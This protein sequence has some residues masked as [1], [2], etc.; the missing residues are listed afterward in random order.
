MHKSASESFYAGLSPIITFGD[1]LDDAA[2]AQ[3]PDDW[4]VMMSDVRDSTNAIA[5]GRY[6]AVNMVGVAT[7]T[8]VKNCARGEA[9]PFVFGG[10]G[11]T[12]LVPPSLR[13]PATEALARLR[14]NCRQMFDLDL[15][16][17]AIPVADI[18]AAGHRLAVC[19]YQ[20]SPGNYL[21]FLAGTGHAYATDR[22]KDRSAD[23]PYLLPEPDEAARHKTPPELTGL[24]CRWE[25]LQSRRG[26][27]L[28]LII[29][30]L[31]D[32]TEKSE[33]IGRPEINVAIDDILD[34]DMRRF[35]PASLTNLR[36]R[37]PPA[38]LSLEAGAMGAKLGRLAATLTVLR[39]SF[40]QLIA[41][42][43]NIRLGPYDPKRYHDEL[44]ANTDYRKLDGPIRLVLDVTPDQA[45]AIEAYLEGEA[46]QGRLRFGR[47]RSGA[48]LMTCLVSDIAAGNHVHFIDGAGGGHTLA[49]L[50]MKRKAG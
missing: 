3:A 39:S 18:A 22:L 37:W 45:D 12:I 20:L 31:V 10:D 7:I 44:V 15:R 4:S 9:L 33:R 11:A 42:R 23:N 29:E 47:H 27:I 28:T 30:P 35:A 19:K 1:C 8:A 17:G 26:C 46:N 25:P 2:Y 34:H 14:D 40:A 13:D 43:L 38:G 48:A 49:A 36:F 41:E 6:K 16:V 32:P 21:G 50:D 24:S 5:A